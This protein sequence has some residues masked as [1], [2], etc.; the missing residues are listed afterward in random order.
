MKGG[1][2]GGDIPGPV[3][4]GQIVQRVIVDGWTTRE[5]AGAFG[6]DE[7]LVV[8]WVAAYRRCGMASLREDASGL[9]LRQRLAFYFRTICRGVA[10]W[11]GTPS[12][13]PPATLSPL[14]RS[15]DDRR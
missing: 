5:A 7:R 1:S 15:H 13:A 10:Q 2:E 8:R 14:R 9:Y 6:L 12:A 3:R 4:R 11:L